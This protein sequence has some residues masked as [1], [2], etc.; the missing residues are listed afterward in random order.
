[1]SRL[2]AR[3]LNNEM[4]VIAEIGMAHDGSLG[5]AKAYIEAAAK[6]GADAVKLQTHIADAE[7]TPTEPFRLKGVFIQDISRYEYWKRTAFTAEQWHLLSNFAKQWGVDFLSSPFSLEAIDLLDNF[8][9][10]PAWKIASGEVNNIPL[11]KKAAGTGKPVLISSGMS[12][13]EELDIA[14]K[15]VQEAGAL[16]A[17]FQCTTAYPCPPERIGINLLKEMKDR[18]NVPVGLSDHSGTIF[19]GLASA[20]LNA[21]LLE[22][23]IT[24]SKEMFGPDVIA[25]VTMEEFKQL[26]DGIRFIE[27]MK[28]HPTQKDELAS[29]MGELRSIF[30]KSI[31]YKRDLDPG[32][33]LTEDDLTFKKPGTGLPTSAMKLVINQKLCK[34]VSANN[35]VSLDDLVCDKNTH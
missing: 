12:S 11:L 25:S 10:V 6:S 21:E 7:S 13:W 30:N 31:V 4:Y 18:Y 1:M 26:V 2:Q 20:A 15:T 17:V 32:H 9:E 22:V 28:T 14:V 16:A 24:M 19:A 5:L 3:L 23:H 8:C 34:P 29:E 33:Q 35:L 27:T